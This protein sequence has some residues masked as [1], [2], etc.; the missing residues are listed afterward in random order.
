MEKKSEERIEKLMR[1]HKADLKIARVN[2]GGGSSG[3]SSSGGYQCGG[4][5]SSN[6]EREYKEPKLDWAEERRERNKAKWEKRLEDK[7]D[8]PGRG[9]ANKRDW[10][11]PDIIN[12]GGCCWTHG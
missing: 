3:G 2:V 6:G 5:Y 1:D 7:L 10:H 4:G 12:W 9:W 8:K 11:D